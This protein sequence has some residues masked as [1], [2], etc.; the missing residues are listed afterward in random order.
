[1][2]LLLF[3]L[4]DD[5]YGIDVA[6][7]VEIMPRLSLQQVPRSPD[8]VA[9]LINYRGQILPVVD[10]SVLIGDHVSRSFL[11][12]RIIMVRVSDIDNHYLGLVA[13]DVTEISKF[14][15]EEFSHTGISSEASAFLDAVVLDSKGM[16]QR[17]NINAL[18]PEDVVSLICSLD[19]DQVLR[20]NDI[21]GS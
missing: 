7:V 12:T 11:S 2:M 4:N 15:D 6:D 5:R 3:S 16:I 13:E 1:M 19:E 21:N 20:G 14:S 8:Y 18:V 10:L 9:G 17:I